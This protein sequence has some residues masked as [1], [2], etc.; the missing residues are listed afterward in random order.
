MLLSFLTCFYWVPSSDAPPAMWS[1]PYIP[2]SLNTLVICLNNNII[3]LFYDVITFHVIISFCVLVYEVCLLC[4][5][6]CWC[7]MILIRLSYQLPDKTLSWARESMYQGLHGY[8]LPACVLLGL[9]VWSLW[10]GRSLSL[11]VEYNYKH[12]EHKLRCGDLTGMYR[13]LDVINTN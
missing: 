11:T 6:M 5:I 13:Q 2:L 10:C 9:W 12:S 7:A 8:A 4:V 1:F 3:T